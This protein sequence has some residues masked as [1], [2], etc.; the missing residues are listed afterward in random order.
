L[1]MRMET[2]ID[3][4]ES[5]EFVITANLASNPDL[6]RVVRIKGKIGERSQV[7]PRITKNAIILCAKFGIE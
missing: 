4:A 3:N 1:L 6:H 5:L 7:G 2:N